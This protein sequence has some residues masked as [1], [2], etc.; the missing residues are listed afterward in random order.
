[1][2]NLPLFLDG[3]FGVIHCGLAL[4]TVFA[5]CLHKIQLLEADR[6]QTADARHEI[7]EQLQLMER[8]ILKIVDILRENRDYLII[9]Y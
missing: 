3:R 9:A 1:M 6:T 2:R 8:T 5:V 4:G 7:Q